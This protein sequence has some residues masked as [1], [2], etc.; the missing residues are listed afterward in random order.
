MYRRIYLDVPYSANK[1]VEA[2]GAQF[3]KNIRR[4][5]FQGSIPNFTPFVPLI[6]DDPSR[7]GCVV[8]ECFYILEGSQICKYCKKETRVISLGVPEHYIIYISEDSKAQCEYVGSEFCMAWAKREKDIPP[9]LLRY[10]KE[11]YSVWEDKGPNHQGIFTCHCDYCK[12]SLGADHMYNGYEKSAFDPCSFDFSEYAEAYKKLRLFRI[13]FAANEALAL[14]WMTYYP[15]SSFDKAVLKN[16]PGEEELI[17]PPGKDEI[18]SYAELYGLKPSVS[19]TPATES[20]AERKERLQR[21]I[22]A[23]IAQMRA[24]SQAQS[25]IKAPWWKCLLKKLLAL[26]ACGLLLILTAAA[27]VIAVVGTLS[28]VICGFLTLCTAVLVF[29]SGGADWS[30]FHQLGIYTAILFG[31]S[32]GCFAVAALSWMGFCSLKDNFPG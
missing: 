27:A 4:W 20:P 28:T 17:L 23:M 11:K 13:D 15:F 22:G 24:Q 29:L 1:W 30:S 3:D 8:Q 21:E 32:V 2:R 12:K 19:T 10:L 7:E 16:I 26:I 31:I 25:R 5:Y 9:T 6:L 14:N 18:T